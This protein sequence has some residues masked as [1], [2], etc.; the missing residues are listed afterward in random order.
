[1]LSKS[2]ARRYAAAFFEIAK[3]QNQL[4]EME[5]QLQRLVGDI[6]GNRELKKVFNHRLIKE[7]DKKAV[8]KDIFGGRISPVLMNFVYLLIDKKRE[9]YLEQIQLQYVEMANAAR[10]ILDASVTSAIELSAEDIKD[11]QKRLS[12]ITGKDVRLTTLVDPQ[13]IGG[14]VIRVGD[15]VIDGSITKR[16]QLLKNNLS[17]AKLRIS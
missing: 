16:L 8:V 6:N 1:M 5:V 9:V 12:D 2:V 14:L 3:E 7:Q 15:R 13:L 4:G 11:L 10:N 17:K